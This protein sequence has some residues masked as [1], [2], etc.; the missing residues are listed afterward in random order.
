MV[1]STQIMKKDDVAATLRQA[2]SFQARGQV[3]KARVQARRAVGAA[4]RALLEAAGVDVPQRDAL[5]A[6]RAVLESNLSNPEWDRLL[7]H[8]LLQVDRDHQLPRGLTSLRKLRF[9]GS[10]SNRRFE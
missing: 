1:K 8:F 4:C 10:T 6:I 9:Y 7:S 2:R 5:S 3:G